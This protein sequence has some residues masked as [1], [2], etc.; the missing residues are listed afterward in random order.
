MR[1]D[2][3]G[4]SRAA[5]WTPHLEEHAC[6]QPP[7][8]TPYV[9]LAVITGA[10]SGIGLQLALLAAQDGYDLLLAADTPFDEALNVLEGS[11]ADIDTLEVDLSRRS[12]AWD[13]LY[14]ALDGRAPDVLVANAGHGLGKAFLDEEIDD[15]I[16]VVDTNITG[17][18]ALIHAVGRDMRDAGTGRI[19]ITGS[20][21]GFMPGAFQAVYN[22][23]KAFVD[24]FAWALRNELKDTGSP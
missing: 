12:T 23:T 4:D 24:S 8:R 16:D 5:S 13:T 11:G 3:R 2:C 21:A 10:S 19:L 22:G 9:P 14:A 18:I 15:A 6:H 7:P 20:I 17:T 1:T